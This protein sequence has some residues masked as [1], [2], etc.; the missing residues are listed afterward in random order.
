MFRFHTGSIR[1]R[2]RPAP[3]TKTPR[4]CFD[5]I[6]VR[7]EV[8]LIWLENFSSHL[9]F[10]FHTGSIRSSNFHCH[11]FPFLCFDSILV[12]LEVQS[13]FFL[14]KSEKFRFHTGSIRREGRIADE[15]IKR[16]FDS[17][18]VRLEEFRSLT[19]I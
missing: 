16:R 11:F 19:R 4:R 14:R 3:A 5:S 7:L 17:I 8:P 6:L 13:A 15:P 18:L 2:K 9:R 1:R 12:R 10:R